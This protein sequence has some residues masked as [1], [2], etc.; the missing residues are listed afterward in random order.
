MNRYGHPHEETLEKLQLRNIDI[1]RTDLHGDI[2]ITTDG[3]TFDINE[4]G[5]AYVE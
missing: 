5:K 4:E 1:Y 3:Q 2:V